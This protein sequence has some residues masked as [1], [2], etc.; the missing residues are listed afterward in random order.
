MTIIPLPFSLSLT[1][2]LSPSRSTDKG[3]KLKQLR[4]LQVFE[5]EVED[6]E[7]WIADME[8]Q[9]ASEDFGRDLISVN[10]LIKSHTV[11]EKIN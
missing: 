10:N 4:D 1:L 7:D 5:Q 9:L 11:R 2:S 8:K 6:I 3:Q